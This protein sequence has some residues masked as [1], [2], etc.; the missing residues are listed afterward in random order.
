MYGGQFLFDLEQ[1]F[2]SQGIENVFDK[3]VSG[4]DC[5]DKII[6]ICIFDRQKQEWWSF[7]KR[8]LRGCGMSYEVVG[9]KGCGH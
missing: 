2:K 8:L 7:Q 5:M 9:I 1:A 4:K 3:N 6:A